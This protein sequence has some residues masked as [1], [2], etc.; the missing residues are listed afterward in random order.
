MGVLGYSKVSWTGSFVVEGFEILIW[1]LSLYSYE[2][3]R[4]ED[5]GSSG[6]CLRKQGS[7]L[8]IIYYT[9]LCLSILSPLAVCLSLA[10]D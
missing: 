4:S 2:S 7:F 5:G 3:W 8:V 1:R 9:S 10:N 6:W